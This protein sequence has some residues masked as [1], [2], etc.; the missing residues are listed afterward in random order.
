MKCAN[1]ECNRG[2]GLVHYRRGWFNKRR[3]CSKNCRDA[4]AVDLAKQSEQERSAMTYVEWL[5]F[6]PIRNPQ[7]KLFPA[8]TRVRA[9]QL[10]SPSRASEY[11]V[12]MSD[13]LSR[14][15]ASTAGNTNPRKY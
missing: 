8:V 2:I 3:Y 14:C 9:R 7:E 15:T 13:V 5:F 11:Q 12:A 1:P 4:F 6:Q 10:E